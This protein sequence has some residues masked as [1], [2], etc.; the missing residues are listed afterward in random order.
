MIGEN[1]HRHGGCRSLGRAPL[2]RHYFI[3]RKGFGLSKRRTCGPA[4]PGGII[5][6][7]ERQRAHP[8]LPTSKVPSLPH[9]F[10]RRLPPS[11]LSGRLP[12]AWGTSHF[13]SS[14]DPSGPHSMFLFRPSA[15]RGREG[16]AAAAAAGATAPPG[17]SLPGDG[18]SAAG[19]GP[20]RAGWRWPGG[21]LFPLKYRRRGVGL[22]WWP[23]PAPPEWYG[24]LVP[25]RSL[26][27]DLLKPH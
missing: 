6:G 16:K 7:G 5:Q 21:I 24:R 2:A 9:P 25:D 4:A 10:Q 20:A 23:P 17:T 15:R 18:A 27:K 13:L 19:P 8:A 22:C 1:K 11:P 3:A 14:P 12:A 26:S